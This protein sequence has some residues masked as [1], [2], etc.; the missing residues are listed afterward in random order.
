M[1]GLADFKRPL[2]NR[3]RARRL[4]GILHGIDLVSWR[5][6]PHRSGEL[7]L[8]GRRGGGPQLFA[9]GLDLMR[10]TLGLGLQPKQLA[11]QGGVCAETV[12]E[13]E[14]DPESSDRDD[15]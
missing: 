2:L 14:R 8:G 13:A 3:H 1:G 7:R 15:E 11:V 10:E 5:R 9:L 6:Q 4:D 12:V